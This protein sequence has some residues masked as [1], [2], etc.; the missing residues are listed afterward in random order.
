[1][2][3]RGQV[4]WIGAGPPRSL[5]HGRALEDRLIHVGL[6]IVNDHRRD[7]FKRFGVAVIEAGRCG[8][9]LRFDIATPVYVAT[10]WNGLDPAYAP[11][12]SHREPGGLS[13]RQAIDLIHTIDRPIV[14][15]DSVEYNPRRAIS[16]ETARGR[17]ASC[18][19]PWGVRDANEPVRLPGARRSRRRRPHVRASIDVVGSI[20]RAP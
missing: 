15:A 7:Q 1:L 18:S 5:D 4:E 17:G 9:D 11:R 20:E 12:M 6:R 3:A 13:P 2:L 8:Q 10:T 19:S 14:A 16:S